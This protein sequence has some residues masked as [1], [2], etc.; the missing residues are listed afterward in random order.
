MPFLIDG[1]M[2]YECALRRDGFAGVCP[3]PAPGPGN[4]NS[5]SDPNLNSNSNGGGSVAEYL[6]NRVGSV[7]GFLTRL[8]L[9]MVL[10]GIRTA[11]GAS[12]SLQ[13]CAPPQRR[14]LSGRDCVFP[15][16]YNGRRV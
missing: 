16:V 14:T 12:A 11:E 6:P 1:L 15:A 10:R 3:A 9:G 5:N 4:S 7:D 8:S 2:S 13:P